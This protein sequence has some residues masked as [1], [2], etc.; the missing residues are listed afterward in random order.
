MMS[1]GPHTACLCAPVVGGFSLVVLSW[2]GPGGALE[3][4][5]SQPSG[6]TQP[7]AV[8]PEPVWVLPASLHSWWICRQCS[9]WLGLAVRLLLVF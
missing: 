4:G 1:A 5:S 6:L 7:R 8:L 2:R 9:L 3:L